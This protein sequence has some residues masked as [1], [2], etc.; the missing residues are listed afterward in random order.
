MEL[1]NT[2]FIKFVLSVLII[3]ALNLLIFK[4]LKFIPKLNFSLATNLFYKF[5]HYIKF[6]FLLPKPSH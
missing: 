5:Q 3:L 1:T 6:S 2:L 4:K